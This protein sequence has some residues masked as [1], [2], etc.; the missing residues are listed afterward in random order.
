[1]K[2]GVASDT[3]GKQSS[4]KV[5]RVKYQRM[6]D[7]TNDSH[8]FL[9]KKELDELLGKQSSEKVW[10]VK[11]ATMFHMTNDS[12]LF[13]KKHELKGK[14]ES[15]F[16]PLYE[17]KMVQMFDHRAADVV[18]NSANLHRP[19][20]Q[21]AIPKTEKINPD[22][23]P[24]PQYWVNAK[25][26]DATWK[27]EWGIAYKSVTAPSNMRTMIAAMVPRCGVGNSMAMLLPESDTDTHYAD[28]ASLLLANFNAIVFD[29]VLRQKVQ[30]QNLN[31]FIVEQAP[32]IAPHRFDAL[33]PSPF[34]AAMRKAKLLPAKSA[35]VTVAD[36]VRFQVLALTYTAH[37]MAAFACDMGYVDESGLVLAPFTWDEEERHQRQAALDAV[38]F[39]LYGMRCEDAA[40]V[41]D[42]FPIIR[43]QDVNTFGHFKTQED[44][45]AMMQNLVP[46]LEN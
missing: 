33:L 44:I 22:R 41:L 4:E 27:G 46:I 8:L 9:K 2:H 14:D 40:Y 34:T 11:Y 1:V 26:V 12:H 6:F 3:L 7:M 15:E 23:Y 36:F 37:D 19:A 24:T 30:G 45:L 43:E 17:G 20:Q 29:F 25:D 42:T 32:V 39:W 18:V 35:A 38:F 13:A 21:E 28:W 16:V 31:W 10:A 5:W